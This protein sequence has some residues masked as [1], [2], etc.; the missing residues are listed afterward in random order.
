MVMEQESLNDY[1]FTHQCIPPEICSN[2]I[3]I[4]DATNEW[5]T[6]S[7][8]NP[9]LSERPEYTTTQDPNDEEELEVS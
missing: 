6:H 3:S 2:L 7:W 5:E 8:T 1:I 9:V 4:F